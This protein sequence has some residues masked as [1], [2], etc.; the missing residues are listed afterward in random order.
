MNANQTGSTRAQTIAYTAT[1]R[2]LRAYLAVARLRSFTRAATEL[3]LS[4]PSLTSVIQQL[5]HIVGAPLFDRTT[6]QVSLTQEGVELRPHAER[7]VEDF[8]ATIRQIRLTASARAQCVRLAIVASVARLMP[9]VLAPFMAARPDVRVQLREGNSNDV[10]RMVRRNEVDIGFA[11]ASDD[12]ELFCRPL[13]RDKLVLYAPRG[14]VL[15]RNGAREIGWEDLEGHDFVGLTRDTAI[16]PIIDQMPNL[17]VSVTRPRYEVSTYP[18]LWALV[19]HGLAVTVAP[20]L[21]AE[22]LAD[23]RIEVLTIR[24]PAQWRNV[25]TLTREGRS[26]APNT[27]NLV[28]AVENELSKIA[29]DHPRIELTSPGNVS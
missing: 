12:A 11:S 25:Y 1:I 26:L 20:A 6:R 29:A 22:F 3:H 16:G 10:R 2:H 19:E 23:E 8:D 17:P 18:S 24:N 9:Q 14:H 7:L 5:E 27:R 4:Q 13:F 21:A 15:T 28:A